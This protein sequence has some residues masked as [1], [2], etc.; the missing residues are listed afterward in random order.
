MG[1]RRKAETLRLTFD[2]QLEGLEATVRL[3][4]PATM[5]HVVASARAAE[6][7][8]SPADQADTILDLCNAFGQLLQSWNYEDEDGTPVP[9]SAE[10]LA[11][12]DLPFVL[13]VVYGWMDAMAQRAQQLTQATGGHTGEQAVHEAELPMQPAG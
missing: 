6:Q 4:S 8:S 7:A 5:R 1:Y 11:A 9:A 3:G 2:G 10:A 13:A 12:E